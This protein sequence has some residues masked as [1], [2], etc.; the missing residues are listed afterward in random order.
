MKTFEYT[1]II[2]IILRKKRHM[3]L[4]VKW[5]QECVELCSDAPYTYWWCDAEVMTRLLAAQ[6]GDRGSIRENDEDP[7]RWPRDTPLSS[8]FFSLSLSLLR[9]AL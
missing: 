2:N 8:N 9:I 4:S 6:L 1:R 7:P 3:V 5:S